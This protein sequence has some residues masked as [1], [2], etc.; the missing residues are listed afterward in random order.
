MDQITRIEKRAKLIGRSE[1][2]LR[3]GN[4][5]HSAIFEASRATNNPEAMDVINRIQNHVLDLLFDG[6]EID[7]KELSEMID[8]PS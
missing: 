3:I 7:K 8:V 1:E 2:R 4:G 6:L 5:I